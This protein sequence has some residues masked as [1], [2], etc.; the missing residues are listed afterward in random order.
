MGDLEFLSLSAGSMEE[1]I[2]LTSDRVLYRWGSLGNDNVQIEPVPVIQGLRFI[3]ADPGE[4]PFERGAGGTC[5]IASVGKG[6]YC[7]DDQGL[8]PR[9]V[10][11]PDLPDAEGGI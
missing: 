3:S 6:V 7:V 10:P 8:T 9:G 2:G 11:L 5:G 1:N 4:F